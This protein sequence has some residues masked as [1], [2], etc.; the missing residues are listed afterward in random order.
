METDHEAHDPD[1]LRQRRRRPGHPPVRRRQRHRRAE[2]PLQQVRHRAGLRPRGRPVPA[3]D[4]GAGPRER[5]LRGPLGPDGGV[6]RHRGHR[7]RA[8]AAPRLVRLARGGRPRGLLPGGPRR[9]H[10]A[11]PADAGADLGSEHVRRAPAGADQHGL[12][13]LPRHQARRQARHRRAVPAQHDRP[14]RQ[15]AEA[16]R[17]GGQR[18]AAAVVGRQRRDSGV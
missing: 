13:A 8:Q 15:V 10:R 9:A 11:A 14:Q 5:P 18:D 17:P 4:L 7:R 3:A 6:R 1:H 12:G 16:G 2:G